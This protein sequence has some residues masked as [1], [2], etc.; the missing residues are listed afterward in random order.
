M[1]SGNGSTGDSRREKVFDVRKVKGIQ[2]ITGSNIYSVKPDRVSK[3]K[4]KYQ[5]LGQ[6]IG[7]KGQRQIDAIFFWKRIQNMRMME[8]MKQ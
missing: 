1:I 6:G 5:C 7:Q 4:R 2:W 8:K 3:R